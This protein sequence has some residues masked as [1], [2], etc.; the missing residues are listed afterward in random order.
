M[1]I[2]STPLRLD[3]P[4]PNTAGIS[5]MKGLNEVTFFLG[6]NFWCWC[7]CWADIGCVTWLITSIAVVS[8]LVWLST[9]WLR[10]NLT[11]DVDV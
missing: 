3:S 2:I 7:W 10:M 6:S 1:L 8:K 11:V 5:K 9:G 4:N